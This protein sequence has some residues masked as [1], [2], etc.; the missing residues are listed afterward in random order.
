MRRHTSF[1]VID[2][3]LTDVILYKRRA[4]QSEEAG[5][6][7]PAPIKNFVATRYVSTETT[8]APMEGF[9]RFVVLKYTCGMV[10]IQNRTGGRPRRGRGGR[11]RR[12]NRPAKSAEDLDAEMEVCSFIEYCMK[13]VNNLIVS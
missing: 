6:P 8:T 3:V 4:M 12:N 1:R 2:T 11:P 13:G 7:T 5:I 10:L 9:Q